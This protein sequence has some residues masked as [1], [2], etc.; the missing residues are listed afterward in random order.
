M[1]QAMAAAVRQHTRDEWCQRLEGSD[2]CFAPVL[3]FEE[4]PLHAH[5][6]ERGAFVT[7]AGVVQPAP[8]PRFDRTPATH[9]Q[10]APQV[11]QHTAQVLQQAGYSAQEVQ[12][13][14]AAGVAAGPGT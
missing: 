7:V 5:A 11:G 1:R 6:R 14:M 8:A 13:L 2:T 9:P 12:D 3:S 4:A 10:P